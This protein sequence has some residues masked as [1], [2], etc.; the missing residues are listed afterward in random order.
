[1]VEASSRYRFQTDGN[2]WAKKRANGN[3][4]R[5]ATTGKGYC[6]PFPPFA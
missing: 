3:G 2:G 4:A 6:N 1:M 5:K